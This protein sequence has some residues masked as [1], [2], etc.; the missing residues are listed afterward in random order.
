VLITIHQRNYQ[1]VDSTS[2]E[3][4]PKYEAFYLALPPGYN[5]RAIKN[6]TEQQRG[7]GSKPKNLAD[8]I[9]YGMHWAITPEGREFW[10]KVHGCALLNNFDR[11]P[12][13]PED[14]A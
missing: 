3:P 12:P 13:L 1:D 4:D 10:E 2:K 5:G 11:L 8:A 14:D 7:F 6:H 9:I